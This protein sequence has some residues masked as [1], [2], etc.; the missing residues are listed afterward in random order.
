MV[1]ALVSSTP[2]AL[3]SSAGGAPRRSNWAWSRRRIMAIIR[4]RR[5][6]CVPHSSSSGISFTRSQIQAS[7]GR[8]HHSGPKYRSN[9][10][11]ISL[12]TQERRWMPFV[13]LAMGTSSSGT[14][15]K[16]FWNN[17]RDT[18]PCSLLTPL[19]WPLVRRASTAMLKASWGSNGLARPKA[20]SS[21][22]EIPASRR[23][24]P[25]YFSI[26]SGAN[27]SKPAGTGVW[28]VKTLPARAASSRMLKKSPGDLLRT[29]HK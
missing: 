27:T 16:N 23:Y 5:R 7:A 21:S 13:M 8:L 10:V 18:S 12:E 9:R 26:R 1:S 20:S 24:S 4:W 28:V 6:S 3:R 22:R 25:K 15:G 17:A 19:A 2:R 14:L 11:P 29:K